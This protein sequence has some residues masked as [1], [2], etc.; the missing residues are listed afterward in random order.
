MRPSAL[1][2]TG[3]DFAFAAGHLRVAISLVAGTLFRRGILHRGGLI[4][5]HNLAQPN[6]FAG[7]LVDVPDDQLRRSGF[8]AMRQVS[9]ARQIPSIGPMRSPP[10]VILSE[11]GPCETRLAPASR[12]GTNTGRSGVE[13]LIEAAHEVQADR[14]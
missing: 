3:G 10:P 12:R 6:G 13:R 8:L 7:D 2:I 5:P 9:T 11:P 1:E 4:R 14:T